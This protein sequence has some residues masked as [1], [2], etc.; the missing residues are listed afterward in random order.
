MSPNVIVL[1]GATGDLAKRKLLPGLLNLCEAGLL[2][3]FR[4]VGAARQEM[5][6]RRFPPARP[7]RP[8]TSSAAAT[9]PTSNARSS[10]AGSATS[11]S[12]TRIRPSSP[13]AIEDAA[14]ELGPARPPAPLSERP[15]AGR[16]GT[17]RADRRGRAGRGLADH[18]GEAVRHRPRLGARPE[19][20]HPRG[21][22]GAEGL[23]NRPLPRQGG[24]PEHPRAALRQRPL[25][26]DLEPLAHRPRADRRPRDALG[27][28]RAEASTTGPAPI[29]TWSSP[30]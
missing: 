19:R 3:P 18:H 17:D 20:R 24:G 23:P 14:R 11:T 22:P 29:A 27:R 13:R 15:A 16:A 7:A 25:R 28:R 8:A 10:R 12:P 4:V 5:S 21:L 1:F 30:T 2:P 9:S 6:D 26:A